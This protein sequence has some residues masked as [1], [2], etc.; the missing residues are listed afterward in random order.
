MKPGADWIERLGLVPHPEGG[1]YREVYRSGDLITPSG[2]PARYSGPRALATA[3]YYLLSGE[4]FSAL[5]RLRS[6][7]IWNFYLGSPLAIFMIGSS[8]ELSEHRLGRSLSAG[9][10]LQAVVPAGHWF[11]AFVLEPGSFSLVGCT[12][13]PGFD[14]ADFELGSREELLRLYP[15]HRS[16]ILKLTR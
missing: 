11:G 15:R 2:L 7:E 1:F 13:V 8:G 5:H 6:D 12:L 3:I 4:D 9:E 14:A 16:A 10:V